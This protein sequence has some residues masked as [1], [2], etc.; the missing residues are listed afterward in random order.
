MSACQKDRSH[1]DKTGRELDLAMDPSGL[2][3]RRGKGKE[4]TK[5]LVGLAEAQTS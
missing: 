4:W 5:D 1:L 2:D 3:K